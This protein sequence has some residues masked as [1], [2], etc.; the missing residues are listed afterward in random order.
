MKQHANNTPWMSDNKSPEAFFQPIGIDALLNQEF[1]FPKWIVEG[2]VPNEG[3]TIISAP[4]KSF[5]SWIALHFALCIAQ[6]EKAFG[7]RDCEK[8]GVLIIDEENHPRIIQERLLK[9]NTPANLPITFVSQKNFRLS[10]DEHIKKILELCDKVSASVIIMDSLVRIHDADENN[11]VEIAKVFSYARSL[12][13]AGKTVIMLHH[14]RKE[15]FNS[16]SS[17]QSRMRGSSDISASVDSHIAIRKDK[18]PNRLIIEPAQLRCDV[19]VDPFE[20]SVLE[21]SGKI[22]FS[23]Y[24]EVDLPKTASEKASEIIMT[25]LNRAGSEGLLHKYIVT[26]LQNSHSIGEKNSRAAIKRL[27]SEGVLEEVKAGGGNGRLVR[28]KQPRC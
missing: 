4:P 25:I 1:N 28:M 19:L 26:M 27:L 11:A 22:E 8:A 24:G 6:G 17:P 10:N 7:M 2:L 9:L 3:I 12:C 21:Q 13:L 14:E 18:A 23:Y 5:K 16:N 15:G 20:V